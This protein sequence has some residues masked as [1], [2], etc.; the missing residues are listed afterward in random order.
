MCYTT[1]YDKAT[2]KNYFAAGS[3]AF[4]ADTNTSIVSY[5]RF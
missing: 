5:V 1:G 2:R 3:N 4:T